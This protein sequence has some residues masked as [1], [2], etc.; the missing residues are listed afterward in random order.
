MMKIS[1]DSDFIL[2]R[3]SRAEKLLAALNNEQLD[4]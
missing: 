4:V 3:N 2:E 1:M